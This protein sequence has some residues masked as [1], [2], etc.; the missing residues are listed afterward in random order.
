MW[1]GRV[2]FTP[3]SFS[4][5]RDQARVSFNALEM[6]GT[7][8]SRRSSRVGGEDPLVSVTVKGKEVRDQDK[9]EC[10][11]A[12]EEGAVGRFERRDKPRIV[13]LLAC[14]SRDPAPQ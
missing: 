2:F 9:E 8:G 7:R 10:R 5:S 13:V 12:G 14:P 1:Y 4:P 6:E 11:Y 3:D